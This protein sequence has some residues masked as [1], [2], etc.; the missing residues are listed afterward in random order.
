MA[1]KCSLPIIGLIVCCGTSA[2]SEFTYWNDFRAT[3]LQPGNLVTVRV[4]NPHGTGLINTILYLDNS[5]QESLLDPVVDGPETVAALVPGPVDQRRYYGFRLVQGSQR[6]LLPVRFGDDINPAP[7]Q[8]T[9]LADDP[10]GDEVFGR[11]HLDLVECRVSFS[12]TRLYAALRNVSGGFPV[13]GSLVFYGYLFGLSDPAETDPEVVWALLYTYTAPGIIGPGLYRVTGTGLNDL[14]LI[15]DITVQEYPAQNT[16]VLSCLLSD[17]FGDP[18]FAAWFDPA[19]PQIAVGA[20]TQRITLTGGAAEADRITGGRMHIRALSRDAVANTP[21]QLGELILMPPGP[22]AYAEIEYA[23][24]QG[25]CPVFA[26]MVFTG[27]NGSAGT[28]PFYPQSLDYSGPVVYRTAAGIPPLAAGNWTSAEVRFS[29]NAVD[30]VGFTQTP[31]AVDDNDASANVQLRLDGAPNP[32]ADRT[33]FRFDLPAAG[34]VRLT[35][36]DLAG[37]TVAVLT[38]GERPAGPHA[39]AWN[40]RDT[41]GNPQPA[42]VYF[43]RLQT[44]QGE[45]VRRITMVR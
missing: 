41:R 10:A 44:R 9:V 15:A 37:R 14:I 12:S 39:V 1:M 2:A 4:E 36:H 34:L 35:V 38:D 40:G 16:L 43:Y 29:D 19:D 13:S 23:D 33:V 28:F 26:E 17:L 45:V 27:P 5:V 30:V 8:L 18:A 7:G 31:V 3:A 24:A 42:G 22:Q 25:D 6:D 20:F 21:P 11:P 32:F